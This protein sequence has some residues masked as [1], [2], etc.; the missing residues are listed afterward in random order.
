[1]VKYGIG[2]LELGVEYLHDNLTNLIYDEAGA[3]SEGTLKGTQIAL[4]ML[5]K[6]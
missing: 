1:M 6:F 2:P 4:S 5:Y 3:A